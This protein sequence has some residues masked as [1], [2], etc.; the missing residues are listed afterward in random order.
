MN[1][2]IYLIRFSKKQ[3][4]H[5]ASASFFAP[6]SKGAVPY[7]SDRQKGSE[8]GVNKGSDGTPLRQDYERTEKEE[9]KNKGQQPILFS[10]PGECP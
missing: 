2:L 6:H 10:L 1:G 5:A 3:E 4:R 9:D 7:K 8:K